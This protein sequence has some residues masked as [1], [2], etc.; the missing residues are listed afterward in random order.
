MNKEQRKDFGIGLLCVLSPFLLVAVGFFL[1]GIGYWLLAAANGMNTP[2]EIRIV[3]EVGE[4]LLVGETWQEQGLF[5]LTVDSIQEISWDDDLL[6][7]YPAEERADFQ[8]YREQQYKVVDI[9]FSFVNIGYE[10]YGRRPPPARDIEVKGLP[11][12]IM[13]WGYAAQGERADVEQAGRNKR[14]PPKT[15]HLRYLPVGKES[16]ENHY[17]VFVEPVTTD[18]EI[19]FMIHQEE[20]AE[21][22]VVDDADP[23]YQKYYW[24]QL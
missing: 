13:A 1:F 21:E 9:N 17:V 15:G 10:G 3:N 14:F 23:Y 19:Q 20:R 8:T 16:G 11:V 2:A 22:T 4:S 6:A 18:L 12:D 24:H 7:A 5:T